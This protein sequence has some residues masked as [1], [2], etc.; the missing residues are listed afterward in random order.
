[1]CPACVRSL[2]PRSLC[3][4]FC[5]VASGC[6]THFLDSTAPTQLPL[7]AFLASWGQL[8]SLLLCLP[9][10]L[11]GLLFHS[12][13]HCVV[14]TCLLLCPCCNYKLW[15]Q[16]P[17]YWCVSPATTMKIDSVPDTLQALTGNLLDKYD[18]VITWYNVLSCFVWVNSWRW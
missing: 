2:D 5:A 10:V 11:H 6:N 12:P 7:E 18:V 14:I 4:T 17:S 16:G 13:L 15:G 1:M 3:C 9:V 8:E